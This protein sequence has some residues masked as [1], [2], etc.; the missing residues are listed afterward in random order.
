MTSCNV[1]RNVLSYAFPVLAG[2]LVSAVF[3]TT[4]VID[5]GK[6]FDS[7]GRMYGVMAGSNLFPSS[8]GN[9][10]PWCYRVLTPHLAHLL[11]WDT[12]Q[13]FR[14][15]AYV[16]T[17]LSL[18]ILFLILRRFRYSSDLS[19]LGVLLYAGVF[20]TLKFSFYSPAY[21]DSQTQ[22]FLL[23]II[24]LTIT[25]RYIILLPILVLSALQKESL[26]AYSLFS[27]LHLLRYHRGRSD[28][29]LGVAV[30]SLI[31]LPLGT[32]LL[33]RYLVPAENTTHNALVLFGEI[34]RLLEPHFW[35]V[36]WQ[37]CFSGLGLL[38][39]VLIVQHGPW[40]GFLKKHVEWK[41]YLLIS[42][43]FLF[44]GIDK[45]RLFLY[46]L[47]MVILLSMPVLAALAAMGGKRRFLAWALVLVLLHFFM[48]G[49]F[50][51]M[52]EFSDYLAKMVPEHSG[53]TYL[54]FLI[55]NCAVAVG[56][57]VFT[58]WFA[59]GEL[60]FRPTIGFTRRSV[61]CSPSPS[62]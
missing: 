44:G 7:D 26:A 6:G 53:G 15:L 30:I 59:V 4:P 61:T 17:L 21:I 20:W 8:M 12:L 58:L 47:P 3:I 34:S 60:Y 9:S 55:R 57:F 40:F 35:V 18:C 62:E 46:S 54:P 29:F 45:S 14:F 49:Y 13:N 33:V 51:P 2:I 25:E 10:A 31:I 11:P 52:G 22:M 38:P 27:V 28:I 19:A 43:L 16:S 50:T 36:L 56:F 32:V 23:L 5:H 24:Y 42:I 48:G 37:A 41:A 1:T 39:V